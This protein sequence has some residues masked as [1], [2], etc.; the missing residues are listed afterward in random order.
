MLDS[1]ISSLGLDAVQLTS[2]TSGSL[3]TYLDGYDCFV[4]PELEAG[5]LYAA[6]SS[7]DVASLES[8][9]DAG[10][11][12]VVSGDGSN[13]G[14]SLL[15]GVFGWSLSYATSDSASCYT[16]DTSEAAGTAFETGPTTLCGKSG[17]YLL[18]TSSLPTDGGAIYQ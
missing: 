13:R 10:G 9:V 14:I 5:D 7:D 6:L 4:I 8:W 3:S 2:F 16:L 11:I 17:T 15:N 1:S 18:Y 12:L